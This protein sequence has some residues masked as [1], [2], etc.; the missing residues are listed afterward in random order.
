LCEVGILAMLFRCD[1]NQNEIGMEQAGP[2]D[3]VGAWFSFECRAS[4]AG[5]IHR[6]SPVFELLSVSCIQFATFDLRVLYYII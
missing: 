3:G 6:C 5:W 4:A 2:A 1:E